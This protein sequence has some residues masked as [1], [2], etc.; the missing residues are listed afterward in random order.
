MQAVAVFFTRRPPDLPDCGIYVFVECGTTE[1]RCIS[2]NGAVY[3]EI[4]NH[5]N[6]HADDIAGLK[7]T[8]LVMKSMSVRPGDDP[9]YSQTSRDDQAVA[10]PPSYCFDFMDFAHCQPFPFIRE[11]STADAD[12]DLS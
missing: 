3:Q 9:S 10:A 6:R 1:R 11:G 12:V 2:N 4:C 7:A 5:S 8:C